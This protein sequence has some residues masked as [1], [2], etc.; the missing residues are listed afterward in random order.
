MA[1]GHSGHSGFRHGPAE[2]GWKNPAERLFY[3]VVSHGNPGN[4]MVKWYI[5]CF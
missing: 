4:E 3:V 5:Q 1:F 2:T